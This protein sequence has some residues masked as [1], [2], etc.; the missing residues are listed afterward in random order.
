MEYGAETW[1]L[2]PS[3]EKWIETFEMWI[4]KR[5]ERVKWTDR[6]RNEAV[7]ERVGEERV[8]LKL[9]GKRK[10]N[11]LGHWVGRNCLLKDALEGMYL[12]LLGREF[13]SRGTVT[14]KEDE[15]EDV[16]WEGMDNI[17][18]CCDRVSRLCYGLVIKEET[19]VNLSSVVVIVGQQASQS[20][21]AVKPA[22]RPEFDLSCVRNCGAG[23][24]EFECS[25]PQLGDLSSKFSG[26]SLKQSPQDFLNGPKRKSSPE[27]V[28]PEFRCRS[29]PSSH[30]YNPRRPVERAISFGGPSV[31]RSE[32]QKK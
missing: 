21:V 29:Y 23:S 19:R 14:V 13:Q 30:K 17:E 28:C 1:T 24:P 18:E 8:I 5:V 11:W 9:M 3:E 6:I 12:T 31:E 20:C 7:L 25:G 22:S 27:R 4:R 10:R 32:K 2:R 26:L 16:R 15:Y